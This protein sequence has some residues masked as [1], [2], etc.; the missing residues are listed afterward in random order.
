MFWLDVAQCGIQAGDASLTSAAMTLYFRRFSAFTWSF[1]DI[2]FLT[3]IGREDAARPMIL[4][5]GSVPRH[6]QWDE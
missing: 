3:S 5:I 6:S 1:G 4:V 2:A